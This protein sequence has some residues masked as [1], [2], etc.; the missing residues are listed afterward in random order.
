MER[1]RY[2]LSNGLAYSNSASQYFLTVC[3]VVFVRCCTFCRT[4]VSL[5][6]NNFCLK[7]EQLLP[8]AFLYWGL[9]EA[10]RRG[11]GAAKRSYS[12][13][14]NYVAVN[15]TQP[16]DAVSLASSDDDDNDSKPRQTLEKK[17]LK[18]RQRLLNKLRL[19]SRYDQQPA[20]RS[21]WN[22]PLLVSALAYFSAVTCVLCARN[23]PFSLLR[24][25]T[26]DFLP[27][28]TTPRTFA[29][30]GLGER[31]ILAMHA[32]SALVGPVRLVVRL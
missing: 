20:A 11:G 12:S 5:R 21:P 17:P 2:I 18:R 28:P 10:R 32:A 3:I 24:F 14:K 30:V 26:A 27:V 22:V 19:Y 25:K 31:Y 4:F 8:L 15:D 16:Y 9:C 1:S 13:I 29:C 23:H 7:N 6:K